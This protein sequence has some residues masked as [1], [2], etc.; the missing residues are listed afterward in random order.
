MPIIEPLTNLRGE[1]SL[2]IFIHDVSKRYKGNSLY[3]VNKFL[4]VIQEFK[5]EG[6]RIN[7]FH[8]KNSPPYKSLNS[9]CLDLGELRSNSLRYFIYNTEYDDVWIGLHGY[10]KQ[11]NTIPKNE[12]KRAIGE[13]KLWKLMHT[14]Y[15]NVT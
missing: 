12:I 1:D 8:S 4:K 5:L 15:Q 2:T 11:S 6:P 9:I 14:N 3:L 13:I 10:I 7:L